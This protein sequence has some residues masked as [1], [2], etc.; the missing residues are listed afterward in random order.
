MLDDLF[1]AIGELIGRFLFS[2]WG[3][4]AIAVVVIVIAWLIWRG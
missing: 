2:K 1:D 4:I 3:L